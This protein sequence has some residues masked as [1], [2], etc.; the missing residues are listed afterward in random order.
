MGKYLAC[1]NAI[2]GI[3]IK[4]FKYQTF[5]LL[6]YGIAKSDFSILYNFIEFLIGLA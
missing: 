1:A 5:A 2:V 3:N 6:T 4:H